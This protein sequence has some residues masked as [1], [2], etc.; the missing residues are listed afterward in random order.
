VK[1]KE[2]K[3]KKCK[4]CG[5]MFRPFSSTQR[6]CNNL[7]CAIKLVEMKKF[8]KS[9]REKRKK[10]EE[11][12]ADKVSYQLNITQPVFNKMRRL[13]ELLWF[14]ERGLEPTCISC[15]K[16]IGNDVWC[17]GH[18]RSVGANSALRFDRMNTYLQHNKGCNKDLSGDIDGTGRTHG[19]KQGLRNRFGDERGN[20]IINYCKSQNY[21]TKFTGSILAE[22][23]AGFRKRIR[24]LEKLLES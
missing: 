13:E 8:E 17:C 23:R 4:A 6:V 15:G 19:Y 14:K 18:F 10:R 3:E 21:I 9:Q 1:K 12:K 22:M 11:I 2:Y 5:K 7:Q 24:E 16:P 20:E